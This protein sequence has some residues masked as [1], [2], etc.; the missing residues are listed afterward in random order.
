MRKPGSCTVLASATR[1]SDT[2]SSKDVAADCLD[3]DSQHGRRWQEVVE[4]VEV[5][6]MITSIFQEHT[7]RIY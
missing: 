1:M 7:S 6:H 3:R 2:S 5:L 4:N